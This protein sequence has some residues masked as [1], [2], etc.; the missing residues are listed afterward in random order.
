MLN[1]LAQKQEK[2][3][4]DALSTYQQKQSNF[5]IKSYNRPESNLRPASKID[6]EMN[7]STQNNSVKPSE[8]NKDLPILSEGNKD[9]RAT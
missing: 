6:C 1:S 2:Q 5:V 3:T 9:Q 8:I 7:S 4:R